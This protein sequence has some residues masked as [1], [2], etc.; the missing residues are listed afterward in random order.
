MAQLAQ[1]VGKNAP[2]LSATGDKWNNHGAYSESNPD[3]YYFGQIPSLLRRYV[4]NN[5]DGRQGNLIKILELFMMQKPGAFRVSKEWVT[6]ETGMAPN[7]YYEA[8]QKL[9]DLGFIFYEAETETIYVRYDYL[10]EQTF[11]MLEEEKLKEEK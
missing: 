6:K 1:G 11:K 10:W 2:L 8:R 5:L 7:K 4:W 3:G 9:Q